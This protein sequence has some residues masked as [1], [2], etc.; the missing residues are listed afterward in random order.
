MGTT[1]EVRLSW[2]GRDQAFRGGEPGGPFIT[3]DGSGEEGPSPTTAL[4][5]SVA[6]CM[7]IDIRHILEKSR[8][9]VTGVDVEVTGTRAE[10]HP[11]RFESV[12][13][14]FTVDGPAEEDEERMERALSL[15]RST[16]CSVLHTL[17]SDLDLDLTIRRS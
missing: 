2:T 17:R 11:R 9:S 10:D 4:L 3:L 1:K 12:S 14:I 7:G 15:S 8:V 13:M 6:A 5:L 16:Y